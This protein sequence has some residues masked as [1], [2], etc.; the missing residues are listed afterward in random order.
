LFNQKLGDTTVQKTASLAF[1]FLS[2]I[3]LATSMAKPATARP[4]V[5]LTKIEIYPISTENDYIR[6]FLS[7]PDKDTT[8][9]AG[10]GYRRYDIHIAKMFE[11]THYQCLDARQEDNSINGY[12][13]KYKADKG[14]I[15]MGQFRISCSLAQDI[16]DTYGL[17]EPKTTKFWYYETR[18]KVD[19]P[20]LNLSRAKAQ[21]WREFTTNFT[22]E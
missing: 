12:I 4:S 7:V 14:N 17:A 9:P 5:P 1:L 13:W 21:K 15:D 22:P 18:K 10:N 19:F 20:T 3:A 8:V 11:I 2:A 6:G 16:V